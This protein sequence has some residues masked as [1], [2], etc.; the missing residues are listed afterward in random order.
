MVVC[1]PV[2]IFLPFEFLLNRGERVLPES[3]VDVLRPL[4]P[5]IV[6]LCGRRA[7]TDQ[8]R[9]VPAVINNAYCGDQE[10]HKTAIPARSAPGLLFVRHFAVLPKVLMRLGPPIGYS[11]PESGILCVKKFTRR[12]GFVVIRCN[13]AALV[14]WEA[15]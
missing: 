14:I 5:V 7:G 13:T 10:Y 11:A 1:P 15:M 9:I 2:W 4:A 6:A 12:Q 3:R 8:R